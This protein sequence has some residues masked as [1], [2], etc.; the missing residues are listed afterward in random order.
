MG[1]LEI[2]PEIL[3]EVCHREG[4]SEIFSDLAIADEDVLNLFETLDAD[5]SGTIDLEEL[6]E[7][8]AKLRGDARRS[9]VI[10]I[11][12]MLQKVHSE[13]REFR[14]DTSALMTKREQLLWEI[15]HGK[16][17]LRL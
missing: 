11:N 2:T 15:S 16:Q 13:L 17:G 5:G 1:G 14:Q 3:D 9:D 12:F 7:G 6:F 8:L 4:V 10:A